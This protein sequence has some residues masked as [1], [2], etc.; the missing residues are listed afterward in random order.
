MPSAKLAAQ[1]RC[2]HGEV[3]GLDFASEE[4]KGKPESVGQAYRASRRLRQAETGKGYSSDAESEATK[5]ESSLHCVASPTSTVGSCASQGS[6]PGGAP[7]GGLP[8]DF[9]SMSKKMPR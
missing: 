8:D 5:P 4:S 6:Q 2:S 9:N 3:L 7:S 1:R